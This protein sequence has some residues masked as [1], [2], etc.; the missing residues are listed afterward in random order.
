MCQTGLFYIFKKKGMTD[1]VRVISTWCLFNISLRLI[2]HVH[3]VFFFV[4]NRSLSHIKIKIKI[5]GGARNRP[6]KKK[7]Q[8]PCQIG[9][10]EILNRHQVDMTQQSECQE[11]RALPNF[12]GRMD[13]TERNIREVPSW[14]RQWDVRRQGVRWFDIKSRTQAEIR[15]EPSGVL[16]QKLGER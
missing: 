13:W 15:C 3:W 4:S 1:D 5:T 12:V 14:E 11:I 8:W 7:T 9:L 2:W 16:P 6:H 10:N